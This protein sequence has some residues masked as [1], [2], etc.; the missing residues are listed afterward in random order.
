[1]RIVFMGT[2]DFAVPVLKAAA[3]TGAEIIGVYTQ[4][5][6]PVGRKQIL[7][8]SP[9]KVYALE[10]GFPVFQPERIKRKAEVEALEALQPDLILVAAYG[11]IL[12]QRILDIPPYGCINM[13]ASLLPKFRGAAPIQ[14][15]IVAGETVT[16]ITA[17][18]MDAGMDTGAMIRKVEVEITPQDTAETLH[19]KLAEAAGSL[20]TFVLKMLEAGETL[21]LVPQNDDEA[22]YAPMLRREDG[23]I[24]WNRTAKEILD[25]IRGFY[26]WPGT[27]TFWNGQKLSIVEA[28]G[29]QKTSDSICP[30]KVH[31]EQNCMYIE[32]ADAMIRV[33]RLQLQ[34]K[35]CMEAKAFL[36]GNHPDQQILGA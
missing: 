30:G 16:G 13:H 14:R 25:Q 36:L 15:A 4:P 5:D 29:T 17:M 27:Y 33:L 2:P 32:T 8:P 9:V 18:Q 1:M 35:K 7:T 21:P 26:P 11:Q 19:D 23:L 3:D 10:Q 34:G 24:D 31:V 20:T 22:T 12:S 28:E 6:R